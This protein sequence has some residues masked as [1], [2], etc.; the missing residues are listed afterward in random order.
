MSSKNIALYEAV[1]S[2]QQLFRQR[3]NPLCT[4]WLYFKKSGSV[5][6]WMG[7]ISSAWRGP[8]TIQSRPPDWSSG[9]AIPF[10]FFKATRSPTPIWKPIPAIP[11][12]GQACSVTEGRLNLL[13]PLSD[14]SCI[15]CEEGNKH[16]PL[17]TSTLQSIQTEGPG[18]AV[19][20]EI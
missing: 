8:E 14:S 11:R 16:C 9:L 4:R 12:S 15:S 5:P 3:G 13:F 1:V 20:P 7:E 17:N 19:L 18:I 2:N 6:W 10:V